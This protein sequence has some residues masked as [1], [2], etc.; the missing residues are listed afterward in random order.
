MPIFALFDDKPAK[1]GQADQYV[2][3]AFLSDFRTFLA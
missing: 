2:C 3:L 1:R